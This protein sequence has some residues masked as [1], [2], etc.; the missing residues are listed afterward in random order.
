[1]SLRN[2]QPL[3]RLELWLIQVFIGEAG[4]LMK[5]QWRE[6]HYWTIVVKYYTG[7]VLIV[8]QYWQTLRKHTEA[9]KLALKPI[10][11]AD[12]SGSWI[13]MMSRPWLNSCWLCRPMATR[14]Q[15]TYLLSAWTLL[16]MMNQLHMMWKSSL[17]SI[18][19]STTGCCHQI[20]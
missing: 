5:I 14:L 1:M 19:M 20:L 4:P 10:L 15:A 7:F 13:P 16:P 12:S 11:Y 9:Q 2:L 18:S 6:V 3:Q 8:M 17:V